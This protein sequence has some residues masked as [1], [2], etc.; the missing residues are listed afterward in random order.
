MWNWTLNWNAIRPDL[1]VG[2]C[3]MLADD[4]DEIRTGTGVTAVL[5]LQHD[6]CFADTGIDYPHHREHGQRI[7]L[8]MKRC[9]MRD[10]DTEDQRRVLPAAVRMLHFIL[11]QKHRVYVHCT[12]GINRSPLV[13]LA[14]LSWIESMP[15]EEALS[16]VKA[17]R[18][19]AIP[20]LH[21]FR[22]ARAE[23]IAT[24]RNRIVKR[25]RELGMDP[26]NPGSWK[27][28]ADQVIREVLTASM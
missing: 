22:G 14:Y 10:F 18:P 8:L 5:S 7:G 19:V 28:A 4:L 21:A 16:L 27:Q 26:D 17:R 12:A 15:A 11:I 2:S 20:D 9:P 3:P 24:H 6:D 25:T 13:V 23:L 1:V